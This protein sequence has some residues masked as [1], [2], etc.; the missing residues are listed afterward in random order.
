M[1]RWLIV[2]LAAASWIGLVATPAF[3][4]GVPTS[5]KPASYVAIE[6]FAL[7]CPDARRPRAR[8]SALLGAR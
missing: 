6:V 1:R 5:P 8:R 3:A 2:M 7:V 4:G